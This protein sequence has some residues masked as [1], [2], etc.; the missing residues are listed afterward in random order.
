MAHQKRHSQFVIVISLPLSK[1]QGTIGPVVCSTTDAAIFRR[2][3]SMT[4]AQP[5]VIPNYAKLSDHEGNADRC[6]KDHFSPTTCFTWNHP[7]TN[8]V[9]NNSD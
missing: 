1:Y 2:K 8:V 3:Q 4:L 5:A 7:Y 6:S 9:P